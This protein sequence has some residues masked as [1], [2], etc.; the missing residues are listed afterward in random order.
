MPATFDPITGTL[1]F[2]GGSDDDQ[3]GIRFRVD[4]D[5]EDR[6]VILFDGSILVGDGTSPASLAIDSAGSVALADTTDAL[7][8][9]TD[10]AAALA[11]DL[12]ESSTLNATFDNTEVEA[13]LDALTAKVNAVIDALKATP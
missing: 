1:T 9:I 5:A 2:V 6:V 7:A 8:A 4:G 12:D 10:A 3:G 13:Q 11:S